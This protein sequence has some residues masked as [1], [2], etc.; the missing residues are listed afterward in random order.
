MSRQQTKSG[1]TVTS[2]ST[3]LSSASFLTL[4]VESPPAGDPAQQARF[5]LMGSRGQAGGSSVSS[6]NHGGRPV[7]LQQCQVVVVGF[8]IVVLM[9]MDPLNP[10]HL[11]RAAAP[12]E[13]EFAKVDR[14]Q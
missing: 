3:S 12:A 6:Q 11:L 14:P 8:V 13:Q 9:K 2:P 4:F 10:R 1:S 5:Q 7:Q